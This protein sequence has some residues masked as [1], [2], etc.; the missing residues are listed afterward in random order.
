MELLIRQAT[1]EHSYTVE[2]INRV[3]P[4]VILCIWVIIICYGAD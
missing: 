4:N 1:V 2:H 3:L